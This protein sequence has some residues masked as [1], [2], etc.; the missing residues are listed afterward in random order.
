M[1]INRLKNLFGTDYQEKATTQAFMLG[2]KNASSDLLW[3]HS[4]EQKRLMQTHGA[5]TSTYLGMS[6]RAWERFMEVS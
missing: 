3:W 4:E 1:F 2:D 6:Y 5:L